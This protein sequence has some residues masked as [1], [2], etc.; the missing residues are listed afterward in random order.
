MTKEEVY[1]TRFFGT[2]LEWKLFLGALVLGAL[3]GSVYD[4]LRALRMSVKHGSAAVFFEDALFMLF[5]G[6]VY[7]TYCTELCRGQIRFFVLAAMLIGFSVYLATVGRIVSLIV[8][9]VVK[10]AK[11]ILLTLVKLVK[12]GLGI[13]C[14]VPFFAKTQEKNQKNPCTEG[15][16]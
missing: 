10:F 7:Y 16:T 8:A 11:N 15:D 2:A 13:L 9:H 3:L 1:A 5:S 14:G 6:M 4:L 12:N